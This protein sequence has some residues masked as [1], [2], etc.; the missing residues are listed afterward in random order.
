M[1]NFLDKLFSDVVQQQRQLGGTKHSISKSS[2]LIK[3]IKHKVKKV[4]IVHA[5]HNFVIYN[6]K[7]IKKYMKNSRLCP[8]LLHSRIISKVK[9]AKKHVTPKILAK[10][11]LMKLRLKNKRIL[12]IIIVQ[13]LGT[14]PRFWLF[15]IKIKKLKIGKTIRKSY[16]LTLYKT[17][18]AKKL[19]KTCK[20]RSSKPRKSHK[21]HRSYKSN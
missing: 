21:S 8:K 5:S 16:V 13:K 18:V 10:N 14:K 20:H 15:I 2:K 4:R 9:N 1:S 12:R 6:V 17:I 3:N 19:H 11:G 7:T